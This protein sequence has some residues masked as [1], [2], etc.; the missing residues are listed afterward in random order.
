VDGCPRPGYL[1]VAGG[2]RAEDRP[3]LGQGPRY[4]PGLGD[5]APDPGARH[6][7]GHGLEQLGRPASRDSNPRALLGFARRQLEDLADAGG[8]WDVEYGRDVW[9]LH[10]LGFGGRQTL[11]FDHIP[12]PW[13]KDLAKRWARRRISTGL[14]LEASRRAVR[15]VERLAQF[16]V[17]P[18]VN[19]RSA[20]R[21]GPPAAGS[22]SGWA[23]V[24]R[25]ASLDRWGNPAYQLVTLIL[26]RCGLRI[27]DAFRLE[28]GCLT[29]DADAAPYLRYFNHKM[30]REA[31]VPIDEDVHRLIT[32]QQ[33]RALERCPAGRPGCS[34]GRLTRTS[35]PLL[36]PRF[37]WTGLAATCG[38]TR[39]EVVLPGAIPATDPAS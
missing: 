1:G 6:R 10:N 19:G 18:A 26:I 35:A 13:L 3:V 12:Q 25:P 8:G 38:F 37:V 36:R 2:K 28:S 29:A 31:L 9:R 30:K 32:E 33:Q 16:L 27:S 21:A 14:C 22:V 7:A 34:S 4:G 5:P 20:Q 11:R 15:A 23:Q 17:G 24:E 39:H